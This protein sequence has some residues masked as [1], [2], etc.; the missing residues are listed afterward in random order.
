MK[1]TSWFTYFSSGYGTCWLILFAVALLTQSHINTGIIGLI[2]FP[3]IGAIYAFVRRSGDIAQ[4]Q[5]GVTL[6]KITP[7]FARFLADNPALTN[8]TPFQQAQAYGF[9]LANQPPK[10]AP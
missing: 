9:W 1:R 10:S 2:G 7:D 4:L 6:E 3:V 8:A 5:A